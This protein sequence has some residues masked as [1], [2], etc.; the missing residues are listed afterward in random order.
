MLFYLFEIF[1]HPNI[2]KIHG[3]QVTIKILKKPCLGTLYDYISYQC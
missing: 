3:K 2:K 1:D